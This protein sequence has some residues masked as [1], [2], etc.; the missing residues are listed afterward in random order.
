MFELLQF[1]FKFGSFDVDDMLLN[2][3]GGV[4]GYL[5]IKL[6]KIL[7]RQAKNRAV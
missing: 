5:P 7:Y 6:F 1:I 2:T 3:L 4:L